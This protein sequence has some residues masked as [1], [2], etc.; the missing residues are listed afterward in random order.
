MSTLLIYGALYVSGYYF[1]LFVQGTLGY[2]AAAAGLSGLPA[3]L[4]L[5]FFSSRFGKLAGRYGPRWFMAVGPVIMALGV[6]WWAR[7]PPTSSAWELRPGSPATFIPPL[8]YLI[9]ILPGGILFGIGLMVMVAPLT[10][11]LM[12][13][14]PVRS[15]GVASAVNNAISRVGPQ[16]ATAAIFVAITAGFYATLA[17][18]LP[19]VDVNSP[20]VRARL[21][22][23]NRPAGS[24][25]GEVEAVRDASGAAFHLAM[26]VSAGLLLAG[27]AVNAIGIRKPPPQ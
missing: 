22:P 15:S 12:T 17:T 13:S 27:A 21:S 20:A 18:R 6:L 1:A 7:I 8:S 11:A 10:T 25:P 9:D 24:S 3:S 5:V 23:L 19:G 4:F 14:V 2:S 26:Q 16:L